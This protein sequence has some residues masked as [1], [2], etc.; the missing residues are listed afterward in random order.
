MNDNDRESKTNMKNALKN[1]WGTVHCGIR[2]QKNLMKIKTGYELYIIIDNY[3]F[4]KNELII[5]IRSITEKQIYY[6]G[7]TT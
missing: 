2:L 5:N 1:I 7:M 3:F 4:A 6:G